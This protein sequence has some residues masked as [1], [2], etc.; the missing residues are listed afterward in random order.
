M[1][2]ETCSKEAFARIDPKVPMLTRNALRVLESRYLDR[3]E[4][5]FREDAFGLFK[6]V[7]EH[8]AQAELPADR[9]RYASEWL[10][11]MI[12]GRFMPNSPT[13][14][15]AGRRFGMLSACFVLPVRDDTTQIFKSVS[16]TAA[17]QKA[18]GGVGF[19]FD[20][21]RPC[22]AYIASSG[23][24]S[25]GPI[26]FWRVFS[27]TTS[28]IQQGSFR[29]GAN[30]AMMR[31]DYPDIIKFIYAKQ[32]LKQFTNYNISVK[33]DDKFMSQVKAMPTAPHIVQWEDQRWVI[34]W[35]VVT[36]CEAAVKEGI[37]GSAHPRELDTCYGVN[38]L[39]RV[40][41]AKDDDKYVTV[42]DVFEMITRNAWKTGEPGLFFVDRIRETEVLP[43]VGKIQAT[44]PCGEQ[45][46]LPNESCNLGSINLAAYVTPFYESDPTH[47]RNNPHLPG[48]ATGEYLV[49]WDG[50]RRDIDSAVRFLDDVV[51]VNQYPTSDITDMCHANRK[52]GLGVMG[53]ADALI[54]LGVQYDSKEGFEWGA[55]FM[56]FV[57]RYAKTA[58][59]D[60]ASEKGSFPNFKG[61]TWDAR[62]GMR[63]ACVTTVA[64]T[65]TIS[66]IAN[67]SG[68]IEP[69]FSFAFKRQVLNGQTLIQ[70]HED[71]EKLADLWGFASDELKDAAF[72]T[73]SI[74]HLNIPD[75]A[76]KLF[77]AAMDI[78]PE[79]H[80]RMQ[81]A[82]Q[83]HVTS[84]ISK[85][86]NLPAAA[87][88]EDVQRAYVNAFE[89]KCKGVTVYRDGCRAMQPMALDNASVAEKLIREPVKVPAFL[90]SIRHRFRC[91][92]GNLHTHI[93]LEKT[94]DGRYREREVFFDLGRSGDSVHPIIDVMARL[95]SMVLRLD[96]SLTMLIEQLRG[97]S[98]F[99][100]KKSQQ[101]GAYTSLPNEL[102]M[103]LLSY[104]SATVKY[105]DA[106]G[107]LSQLPE[108]AEATQTTAKPAKKNGD[109]KTSIDSAKEFVDRVKAMSAAVGAYRY[110]CPVDGC[111]GRIMY[112]EGCMKCDVCGEGGC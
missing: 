109:M 47:H 31:V 51:T 106:D 3:D 29:R 42:G 102:A 58:S 11:M 72:K 49:D 99:G 84:S 54:K 74:Q 30:M 4:N 59:E 105:R 110:P 83:A 8:V 40:E 87:T 71:F 1:A 73:G 53:F 37:E 107:L 33:V 94:A 65:G 68:G 15:N 80:I 26:S 100:E 96:G 19:A 46:L 91:T 48:E 45:P 17:I 25:S 103:A 32:D 90:P 85:T 89:L 86:I 63:N 52:I 6:R 62:P 36:R 43:H 16:D 64:P 95:S 112:A 41:D 5:G 97:H 82:F 2:A 60:L 18:G 24:Q 38:D 44:N 14:M 55:R 70:L 104:Y 101:T 27:E 23:G 77:R 22:G 39:V 9:E 111:D 35:D 7:A 81:A 69:L 67:C 76:K 13:L 61:S 75:A 50:L 34:P 12:N 20:E 28:A 88:V 78:K 92:Y 56:K 79:D 108:L 21:L 66:I 93:A 10:D 57:T 98:A